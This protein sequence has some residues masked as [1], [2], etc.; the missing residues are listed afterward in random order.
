MA[1]SSYFT[2]E[3]PA[4]PFHCTICMTELPRWPADACT[5]QPCGHHFHLECA[6]QWMDRESSCPNC[7][8]SV[9]SIAKAPRSGKRRRSEIIVEQK[10]QSVADAED[11]DLPDEE[12]QL[13][14]AP[15]AL[16][17]AQD[18]FVVGDDD[19][20]FY[21]SEEERALAVRPRRG[22]ATAA[23]AAQFI[24]EE[25][26]RAEALLRRSGRLAGGRLRRHAEAAPADSQGVSDD[27]A[28]IALP[29]PPL[30][31]G[32]LRRNIGPE[33][34]SQQPLAPPAREESQDAA[35]AP[36]SSQ[37]DDD[38]DESQGEA[39]AAPQSQSQDESWDEE[40]EEEAP[41]L[42]A[43]GDDASSDDASAPS[44]L[45]AARAAPVDQESPT[46][47]IRVRRPPQP[48]RAVT[49]SQAPA[50]PASPPKPRFDQ[51]VYQPSPEV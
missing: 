42:P 20:E 51:Y 40:E 38:W 31:R 14:A 47:W 7:K 17:Y 1:S 39:D 24:Q 9:A 23:R 34:Q 11:M 35:L 28:L 15:P 43:H 33:S 29:L 6:T 8:A 21:S 26:A 4:E 46:P 3:E 49:Q 10:K 25:Q 32:R 5:L 18:G 36:E 41:K 19:V 2:E 22:R 45:L 50:S 12:T 16:G 37:D 30:A 48:R 27:E 44:S 13:D